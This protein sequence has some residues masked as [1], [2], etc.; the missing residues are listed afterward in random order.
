MPPRKK[1]APASESKSISTNPPNKRGRKSNASE[2]VDEPSEISVEATAAPAS[3][4][5]TISTN[6]PNKRGRKSN[7]SEFVDEPSEIPIEVTA[8]PNP[9]NKRGR[10]SNTPQVVDEPS[11]IPVEVTKDSNPS[12]NNKTNNET[13]IPNINPSVN[14]DNNNHSNDNHQEIPEISPPIKPNNTPENKSNQ[15]SNIKKKQ[16][17]S[18]K[19]SNLTVDDICNHKLTLVASEYWAPGADGEKAGKYDEKLMKEIY[20]TELKDNKNISKILDFSFYLEQFLWH[21]FKSSASLEHLLSITIM[22]NEK[23]KESSSIINDLAKDE[24]KFI[25]F[26]E[27]LVNLILEKKL[28][29]DYSAKVSYTLLLVNIFRSLENAVIRKA[30]LKYLSLPIWDSLSKPK[31]ETLLNEHPQINKH[32]KHLKNQKNSKES[33]KKSSTS[34]ENDFNRESQ[35]FPTILNEFLHEISS[36]TESTDKDVLLYRTQY[37][38]RFLE[39]IIDLLSQLPTR[40]FLNILLEDLHF[41]IRCRRSH[42]FSNRSFTSHRLFNNLLDSIDNYMHFEI[43]DQ[44]G[45]A[46]NSNNMIA[47]QNTKIHKLQT[48]AYNNHRESLKDIVFSSTGSLG[49]PRQLVKFLEYLSV[50]E[51][52]QLALELSIISERDAKRLG[53]PSDSNLALQDYLFDLFSD[54]FKYRQGQLDALNLLPLHPNEKLL[55]DETQIPFDNNYHGDSVLALPK[56]NLQYLTIY[57]FLLRNFNLYRLESAFEIREDLVDTIKRMGPRQ[58]LGGQVIFAGWSRMAV[59][60]SSLSITEV[61]KPSIGEVIPAYVNCTIEFDVSKFTGAIRAEWD[62]IKDHDVVFLVCIRNPSATAGKE[63]DK[64]ERERTLLSQGMKP[65]GT[66]DFQWE[67]ESSDFPEKYGTHFSFSPPPSFLTPHLFHI[68]YSTWL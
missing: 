32:W 15:S 18:K 24:P 7:A 57:D 3:E 28:H 51:L 38:A 16:E 34:A 6:P 66:R 10:K 4:S 27:S 39:L 26:F 47:K 62:A 1:S 2:V 23:C 14:V 20:E 63:L 21:H 42:V 36:D 55:W 29:G 5:K 11:E 67:S 22:I 35:W 30:A 65:R 52:Y 40:R 43:D 13:L 56:L 19:S 50:E 48:L 49:N 59:P 25:S 45:E 37:I 60:T 61:A 17:R 33:T 68:P 44:S 58:N 46:L 53:E 64:F 54:Y 41:I 9:P 31:L 8:A 12:E